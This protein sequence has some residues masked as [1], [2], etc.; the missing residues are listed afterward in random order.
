MF[1]VAL[2]GGIGSGKSEAARQ[3]AL[4]GVP[5]VDTDVI[6]HEL[7]ATG[8]PM[9]SKIAQ[10][11]GADVLNADGSLNRGRLRTH[12]LGAPEER[13]KLENLLHPAIHDCAMAQ[14]AQNENTL[15]PP[16]QVLVIPLLFE[17][18]RYRDVINKILVVDC[19]ESMQI[20][21]AMA[22]SHLSEHEVKAI[23]TAQTS[24]QTRLD[25]A[26]EVI[27]N[28]GTL[29]ELIEKINKLHK[30]LI[31]TCIVSK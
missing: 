13:L 8:N 14:L 23:M 19:E 30:K 24:R 11:F 10:L 12:V 26:D 20:S 17:N 16:Y 1:I 3:F 22:R 5:I 27:K 31:K 18:N 2:T 6:A 28:N 29:A 21:R 15:Q 9:L 7:T 25:G 4:L